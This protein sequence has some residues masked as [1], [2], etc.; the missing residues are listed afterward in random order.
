MLVDVILSLINIIDMM[1]KQREQMLP[2][3]L[4]KKGLTLNEAEFRLIQGADLSEG[5]KG[6]LDI[7]E[8]IYNITL[9]PEIIQ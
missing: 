2:L 9:K 7:L 8:I 5:E 3:Y 1:I 6:L 4:Y